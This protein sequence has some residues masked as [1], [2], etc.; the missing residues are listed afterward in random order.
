MV[1]PIKT[2]RKACSK[3]TFDSPLS[4]EVAGYDAGASPC[5]MTAPGPVPCGQMK[6]SQHK[7]KREGFGDMTGNDM[8]FVIV[9]LW[10]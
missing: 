10:D 9:C 5:G 7:T 3:S 4:R 2:E 8:V 1:I 6:T